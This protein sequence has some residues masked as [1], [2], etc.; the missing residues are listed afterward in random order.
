MGGGVETRMGVLAD[1]KFERVVGENFSKLNPTLCLLHINFACD[2][3]HIHSK[4]M[5]IEQTVR[6]KLLYNF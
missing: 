5:Q 4:V 2:Y 6:Y 1:T 3:I